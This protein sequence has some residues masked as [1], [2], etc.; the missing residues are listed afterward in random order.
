M[1]PVTS[2]FADIVEGLEYLRQQPRVMALGITY[3]C[4][5]AG[6]ISANI[7]VV[8]LAKDLLSAGARGYGWIEAGLGRWRDR[9]RLGRG[10]GGAKEAVQRVDPGAGDAGGGPYA[11]SLRAPAGGGGGNERPVRRMPRAWRGADAILDH[12]RGARRTDGANTIGV[13][14]DLDG[15]AGDMSFT[16]GWFAQN[17]TLSMAFLIL[18]AIYGGGVLAAV[19]V[20]TFVAAKG[21]PAATTG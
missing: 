7:L 18:G 16:L 20:G 3:A 13:F 9:R 2:V 1:H 8:A 17:V 14:G 19:R 4:M 5:M 6:V 15:L 10:H 21:V 12:D 11:V